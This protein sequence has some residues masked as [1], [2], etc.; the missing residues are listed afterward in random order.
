MLVN[1]GYSFNVHACLPL[2]VAIMNRCCEEQMLGER[3]LICYYVAL[4]NVLTYRFT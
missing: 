1:L 2:C 3:S 4:F